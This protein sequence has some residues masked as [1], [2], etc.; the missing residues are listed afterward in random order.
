MRKIS[1]K[2]SLDTLAENYMKVYEAIN[3]SSKVNL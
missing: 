2:Y 1:K 3:N